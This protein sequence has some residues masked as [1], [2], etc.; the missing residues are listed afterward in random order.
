MG[1][2]REA[3]SR[4]DGWLA[5]YAPPSAALL[6]APADRARIAEAEERVGFSFPDELVESLGCHDGLTDPVPLMPDGPVLSAA[7]IASEY[8]MVM[9][10]A[11]D[12]DGAGFTVRPWE[13]EPW[14]HERWLPFAGANGYLL[15]IDM[16]AGQPSGRLGTWAH[17]G[18]GD[19]DAPWAGLGDYLTEV[20]D[21]L[22]LGRGARSSYPYLTVEGELWWD[23]ET[24][25]H[26]AG[27][28]LR[29]APMAS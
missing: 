7:D 21:A 2:V 8:R 16:R 24:A 3:W 9:E 4:I 15:I 27:Q 28:P 11:A 12:E 14:W 5:R 17:D 10:I 13:D 20:A 18:T 29:R 25:T 22:T 26:L 19:F 1:Q 6:A 23:S